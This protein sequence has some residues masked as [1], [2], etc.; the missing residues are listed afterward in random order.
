ML[1]VPRPE[2]TVGPREVC[3]RTDSK[4]KSQVKPDCPKARILGGFHEPTIATAIVSALLLSLGS[5]Q[6]AAADSNTYQANVKGCLGGSEAATPSS[7]TAQVRFSKSPPAGRPQTASRPR[8]QTHGPQG[9]WSRDP[10][11]RHSFSVTDLSMISEH[12]GAAAA[13]P[14]ATVTPSPE[15]VIA[16]DPAS[17]HCA[18]GSSRPRCGHRCARRDG[19]PCSGHQPARHLGTCPGCGGRLAPARHQR[20]GCGGPCAR[21]DGESVHS[22]PET[23]PAVEA[24]GPRG[25]NCL[26]SCSKTLS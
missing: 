16:P 14:A 7:R 17:C 13:R 22:A 8:R 25:A 2:I 24:A 5:A 10:G 9:E 3:A 21:D 18:S 19:Q 23:A 26:N 12:C 6:T 4:I 15:T 11:P 20:T 1:Q